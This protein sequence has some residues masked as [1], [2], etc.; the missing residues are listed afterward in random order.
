MKKVIIIL[1]VVANVLVAQEKQEQLPLSSNIITAEIQRL[2]EEIFSQ[3][4]PLLEKQKALIEQFQ[5]TW[6]ETLVWWDKDRE[7]VRNELRNNPEAI[8][9]IS[10][11]NIL[12][13][14]AIGVLFFQECLGAFENPTAQ[15]LNGCRQEW[16]ISGYD[17][18]S[19]R[20]AKNNEECF[21]LRHGEFRKAFHEGKHLFKKR[22]DDI[23]EKN[24]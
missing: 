16:D 2:E 5:L 3:H 24:Q 7:A 11:F 17:K 13:A 20:V 1:L 18:W 6:F 9:L 8:K 14:Q 4:T 10:D 23:C 19:L 21:K 15:N 12:N 22:I